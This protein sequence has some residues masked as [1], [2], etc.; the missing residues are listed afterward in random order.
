MRNFNAWLAAGC[1]WSGSLFGVCCPNWTYYPEYEQPSFALD[2]GLG[3]RQDNL[4][5]SIAGRCGHP[6]TLSSARWSELQSLQGYGEL[7]YV[8]CHNYYTRISGA[9]GD[10]QKGENTDSAYRCGGRRG[11]ILRLEA[12]AG[13]GY[14]ADLA[15]GFG[16]QWTSNGGRCIISPLAGYSYHRQRLHVFDGEI[17]VNRLN[18]LDMGSDS[19]IN[20]TYSTRW[21]GPWIGV[22]AAVLVECNVTLFGTVE[23]HWAQ[24]RA[25][26]EWNFP[27][28]PLTNILSDHIYHRSNGN[29]IVMT[30][31]ANYNYCCNW[32]FGVIGM[33]QNWHTGH[34]KHR[35]TA[36]V[37]EF[38]PLIGGPVLVRQHVHLRLHAVRWNSWGAVGEFTYRW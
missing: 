28:D 19:G 14:V 1:I 22:D 34:G 3:Y 13:R 32:S 37:E 9:Y 7:R 20:S 4:R 31:G 30:L 17:T 25:V 10:I 11:E 5:W 16:Y 26:G 27:L 35:T 21:Q 8:S 38:D 23:Y 12:D 24:Y 29:G 18:P 33:Y 36:M 15:A 2:M 6:S